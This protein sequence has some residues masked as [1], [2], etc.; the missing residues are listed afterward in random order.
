MDKTKLI[1][2]AIL[3]FLFL[4]IIAPVNSM[5]EP[6]HLT[7]PPLTSTPS[8]M[9]VDDY[10]YVWLALPLEKIVCR[11]DLTSES[12]RIVNLPIEA[13]KILRSGDK[14]MAF[15]RGNDKVILIDLTSLEMYKTVVLPKP[16]ENSWNSLNGFW[17]KLIGSND[18]LLINEEGVI[19]KE[20]NIDMIDSAQ[21]LSEFGIYVWYIGPDGKSIRRIDTST[22]IEKSITLNTLLY[23]IL[24]VSENEAWI[25]SN[26]NSISFISIDSTAPLKTF[27]PKSGTIGINKLYAIEP[28]RIIFVNA[29]SGVIGEIIDDSITE[30]SLGGILP[31]FSDL[32]KKSKVYFIDVK[33]NNLGY[34]IVSYSP[35][36]SEVTSTIKSESELFIEATIKDREM[37]IKD[38]YPRVVVMQ[39]NKKLKMVPMIKN[40]N[41]K[42]V[43]S[44]LLND[45]DGKITFV[46]EVLDWGDNLIKSTA[47]TFSIKNGII[48]TTE[49]VTTTKSTATTYITTTGTNVVDM[50]QVM[51]LSIELIL[52]FVL[53][54]ALIVVVMRRPHRTRKLKR[55]K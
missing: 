3:Q 24:A 22:G 2:L 11:V 12:V 1:V 47:G 20:F 45:L 27:K 13:T 17:I 35:E 36:I 4:S 7:Y 19:V 51:M 9:L 15:E 54:A 16:V 6:I 32:L 21:G 25:I 41:N 33:K 8:D 14:I 30:R 28:T 40:V 39:G 46:I 34:V 48:V 23:A 26:D 18:L 53:L 50:G 29:A 10:G 38:G 43:A 44:I 42:F 31:T 37:D 55:S 49:T 52:L 5:S